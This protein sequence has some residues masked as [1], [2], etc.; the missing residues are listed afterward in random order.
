V[1]PTNPVVSVFAGSH[2]DTVRL[3][4]LADGGV[5]ESIIRSGWLL[6]EP[7]MRG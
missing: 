5:T 3:E 6:D 4:A 7:A 1:T 2:S